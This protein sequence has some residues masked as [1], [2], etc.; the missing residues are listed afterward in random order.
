MYYREHPPPHFHAKYAGQTGVFDLETL[1]LI[2]GKLPNRIRK[3]VE[4]WAMEHRKELLQ[5]WEASVNGK[6]P[7]KIKPL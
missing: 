3:F 7:K 6:H 1:K 4:E 5:N 2:E